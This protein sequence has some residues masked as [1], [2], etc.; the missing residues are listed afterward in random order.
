MIFYIVGV[1]RF[2]PMDPEAGRQKRRKNRHRILIVASILLL[3]ALVFSY[4]SVRF[5][6]TMLIKDQ[7]F[8]HVKWAVILEGQ[9]PDMER[10]DFAVKLLTEKKV[11]T[12][13]VLGKRVFR[14]QNDVDFYLDDM[15]QQGDVDVGQIYLFRHDDNSSLEEAYSII[16]ALKLKGIDTVLLVTRG[17]ATRRVNAI[18]NKLAAGKPVFITTDLEDAMFN[19]RTW[20]HT[21]EARKI[22]F[23]EWASLLVSKM[24]LLFAAQANPIPGKEYPLEWAG[25]RQKSLASEDSLTPLEI[26]APSS[27]STVSAADSSKESSSSAVSSSSKTVAKK[28]LAKPKAKP[29]VKSDKKTEKKSEKKAD[30]HA[31]KKSAAASDDE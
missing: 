5:S 6:G 3:C 12:V 28:T 16:P 2:Y 26:A 18:F 4:V 23:K 27:S 11:D 25:Q 14:N 21:R 9:T 10:T 17:A 24:E 1:S 29:V 22:W 19:P 13:V 31:K 20:I 15:L 8:T 30:K 7:P